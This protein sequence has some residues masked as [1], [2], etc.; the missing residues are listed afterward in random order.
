[1]RVLATNG[2]S[3]AKLDLQARVINPRASAAC[4]NVSPNLK[5]AVI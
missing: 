2:H 1:M 3:L 4:L 5:V